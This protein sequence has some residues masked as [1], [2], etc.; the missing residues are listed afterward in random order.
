MLI[1][2][3]WPRSVESDFFV[4]HFPVL[5]IRLEWSDLRVEQLSEECCNPRSGWV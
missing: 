4:A 2:V 5:R 3:C 1:V